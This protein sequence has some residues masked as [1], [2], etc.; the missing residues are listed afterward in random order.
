VCLHTATSTAL[1]LTPSGASLCLWHTRRCQG[2]RAA[3]AERYLQEAMARAPSTRFLSLKMRAS[4]PDGGITTNRDLD[5]GGYN[6]KTCEAERPWPEPQS[7]ELR[8]E[9]VRPEADMG[10]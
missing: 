4:R 10:R 7:T 3:V 6:A 5:T 2:G 8:S 1:D 9:A